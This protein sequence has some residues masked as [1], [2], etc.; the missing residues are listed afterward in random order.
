[1]WRLILLLAVGITLLAF[2][3]R[4]ESYSISLQTGSNLGTAGLGVIYPG[5]SMRVEDAV[6]SILPQLEH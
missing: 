6:G 4:E 2:A 3:C 1:M 5:A